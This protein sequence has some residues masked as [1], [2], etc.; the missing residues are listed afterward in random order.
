MKNPTPR[1]ALCS[2][3]R[4]AGIVTLALLAAPLARAD[5]VASEGWS[6]ATPPRASTAVGYLVLTNTGSEP[7]S[8]LR[9]ISPVSDRVMIHRSSIDHNGIARMWPVGELTLKPGETFRFD[10]SAFHVMFFDINAPFVAGTK[11]PLSLLFE[12]EK[13]VTVMLEVRPLVPEA[14]AALHGH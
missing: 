13:E 5:I 6:R 4:R 9:I 2:G 10:P 8:L 11:V 7:R 3:L 14:T 1:S 12:D